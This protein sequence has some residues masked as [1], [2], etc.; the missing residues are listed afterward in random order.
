[1]ASLQAQLRDHQRH[2]HYHVGDKLDD[3]LVMLAD[4]H[5]QVMNAMIK[6]LRDIVN[7]GYARE[8]ME[9]YH[10]E[11]DDHPLT[12]LARALQL[13]PSAT[14]SLACTDK[15][16]L[17]ELANKV[18]RQKTRADAAE[19][20]LAL[21]WCLAHPELQKLKSQEKRE[22]PQG[23]LPRCAHQC[24]SQ[25]C[26]E[27]C[28][29][30]TYHSQGMQP[31]ASTHKC[32]N[33]DC[34]RECTQSIEETDPWLTE[35]AEIK[36][37]QHS[38][39]GPQSGSEPLEAPQVDLSAPSEATTRYRAPIHILVTNFL[40]PMIS[41]LRRL[42][43]MT[44]MAHTPARGQGLLAANFQAATQ[45][46]RK[47]SIMMSGMR[48]SR[49][50]HG[51]TSEDPDGNCCEPEA[52]SLEVPQAK[53]AVAI[54]ATARDGQQDITRLVNRFTPQPLRR[55]QAGRYMTDTRCSECDSLVEL[56]DVGYEDALCDNC[57]D[58]ATERYWGPPHADHCTE[59]DSAPGGPH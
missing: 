44:S 51:P 46:L 41:A 23:V 53:A 22:E 15:A 39:D 33:H 18:V 35:G 8:D 12:R 9:P 5:D 4:G 21:P 11:Q 28:I 31:D 50:P 40:L 13:S 26:S 34:G 58:E 49:R 47:L 32:S 52:K 19:A 27:Q 57:V 36:R 10:Q 3:C 24:H 59:D 55:K 45:R 1:M 54:H 29:Y 7:S 30:D 42:H 16:T 37:C 17:E 48:R 20:I 25:G 43:G 14:T 56:G 38:S 2:L 6:E